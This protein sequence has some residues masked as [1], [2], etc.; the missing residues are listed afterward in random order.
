MD[1]RWG[2]EDQLFRRANLSCPN[3]DNE[4]LALG[5]VERTERKKNYGGM[6]FAD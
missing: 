5:T 4:G 1:W 3:S 2:Q 6:R